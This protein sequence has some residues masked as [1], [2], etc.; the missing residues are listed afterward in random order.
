MSPSMMAAFRTALSQFDLSVS[1]GVGCA[2]GDTYFGKGVLGFWHSRAITLS[3]VSCGKSRRI[4][5]ASLLGDLEW[6]RAVVVAADHPFVVERRDDRRAIARGIDDRAETARGRKSHQVVGVER[7]QRP[8][9]SSEQR[10]SRTG[11]EREIVE[12]DDD[13][14]AAPRLSDRLR[15]GRHIASGRS[16]GRGVMPIL[17]VIEQPHRPYLALER[18]DEVVRRQTRDRVTVLVDDD[19]VDGDQLDAGLENG[20]L[21]SFVLDRGLRNQMEQSAEDDRKTSH[22]GSFRSIALAHESYC[23]AARRLPRSKDS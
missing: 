17:A 13:D 4:S 15:P 10:F 14:A 5:S 21:G 18:D 23:S 7:R 16:V 1:E 6:R 22:R 9:G 20:L 2:V 8:L 3:N 12:H 11:L 19:R